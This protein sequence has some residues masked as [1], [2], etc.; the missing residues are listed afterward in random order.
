MRRSLAGGQSGAIPFA[1]LAVNVALLLGGAAAFA[2]YARRQGWSTMWTL[3]VALAPGMLLA[4]ERDLSDPLAMVGLLSGLLLL[5]A[6][7]RWPAA[8][9]LTVAVLT[10]EVTMLAIVAD[11]R[12]GRRARIPSPRAPRG[13]GARSRLTSGRS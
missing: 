6:G 13:R 1:L 8:L 7:R 9:G 4:T 5:R 11:R 10:R 2:V 3:A 12:R